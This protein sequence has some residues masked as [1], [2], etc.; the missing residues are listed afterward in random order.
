MKEP[1]LRSRCAG[2][3]GLLS[4]LFACGPP[5]EPGTQKRAPT[6][7]ISDL[8]SQQTPN[9]VRTLLGSVGGWVTLEA[10]KVGPA[11]L[12]PRLEQL[13]ISVPGWT[14]LG[15]KGDLHLG[16]VNGVLHSTWFYPESPQRYWAALGAAGISFDRVN[17]IGAYFTT[18]P[19]R[20]LIWK[21]KA[22]DGRE[23]VGWDD[24]A[25]R[26]E[27]DAWISRCS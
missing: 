7:L 25:I 13:S 27:I 5:V 2:L 12:C 23:Y 9:Q 8:Q 15:E 3:A 16:F 19:P 14:H 6:A 24:E 21:W 26:E 1:N 11:G 10:S 4:I 20:T 22:Y 17:H 18:R